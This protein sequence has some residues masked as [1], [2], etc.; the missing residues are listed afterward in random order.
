MLGMETPLTSKH[1]HII[2]K[3]RTTT[4][5]TSTLPEMHKERDRVSSKPTRL[6]PAS[7]RKTTLYPHSLK[8]A[9]FKDSD[10]QPAKSV[11][12]IISVDY[13]PTTSDFYNDS[14]SLLQA[15]I[16]EALCF[17]GS[18][19]NYSA[20][21]SLPGSNSSLSVASTSLYASAKSSSTIALDLHLTITSHPA[22]ISS[23]PVTTADLP[24]TATCFIT[25]AE[26]QFFATSVAFSVTA[27]GLR[28]CWPPSQADQMTIARLEW[29]ESTDGG[30]NI[31]LFQLASAARSK[32]LWLRLGR[33]SRRHSRYSRLR[34]IAGPATSPVD[35]LEAD[36]FAIV[37]YDKDDLLVSWKSFTLKETIDKPTPFSLL[38]DVIDL[39]HKDLSSYVS[40][41]HDVWSCIFSDLSGPRQT[42]AGCML[43]SS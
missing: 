27:T 18:Y 26:Y 25:P 33:R 39:A 6:Y 1:E 2:R 10:P 3:A 36:D 40:S 14:G 12:K 22:A 43:H 42:T 4:F 5:A 8:N 16:P 24:T 19:E 28:Q 20:P 23:F 38:L 7:A 32:D 37:S 15:S 13:S 11:T 30:T 31:I 29:Y 9:P 41:V 35:Q 21:A 34:S 17:G